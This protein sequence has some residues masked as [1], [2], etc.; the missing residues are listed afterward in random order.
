MKG[1]V[2]R[3]LVVTFVL[4]ALALGGLFGI[5]TLLIF[6]RVEDRM[7][8]RGLEQ[9]LQAQP[10]RSR[11]ATIDY[12]GSPDAAPPPFRQRLA[13]LPAGR[14]EW[15]EATRETHALLVVDETSGER[16]VAFTSFS[17]STAAE[18]RLE[19]ALVAGIAVSSLVALVLARLLAVRIVAPIERL[20]ER[21]VAVPATTALSAQGVDGL[22]P[23]DL[24]QASRD[25]EIGTLARA[26]QRAGH[27]LVASADRERRFLRE[28]SHELRTPITIIQGV[29]DLLVEATDDDDTVT[30]Q[31]LERLRR[32]LRRMHTSVLSLL[33]MARAEHRL[34]VTELPAFE[35][36]LEDLVEEARSLAQPGV[37]VSWQLV[38]A[39]GVG[40]AVSMLIVAL[41]NLARNAVQH[42]VVG[43]V[44]I[45]VDEERAA[46]FDTGVG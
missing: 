24:A 17:E 33:A 40:P 42:T 3:Q 9:M 14:Y 43:S 11:P 19:L 8:E 16:T 21:L 13:G 2:R 20:S 29:S 31:R 10:G 7:I 5:V 38:A 30:R 36:Q 39:P 37:E 28:A 26:L 25:D 45:R 12:V 4:F 6:H 18:R 35:H 41:S 22:V 46:V 1:G 15:E 32:S 34:T 27:E 23:A 44:L